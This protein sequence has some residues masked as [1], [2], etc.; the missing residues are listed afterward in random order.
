MR[1]TLSIAL[2]AVIGSAV[3]LHADV[4]KVVTDFG[5]I[6]SLVQQVMGDLGKPVM[7]LPAGGDPHDFQMRPSQAA[8]LSAADLVFWDGPELMPSLAD[9]ITTLGEDSKVVALLHRGGGTTRN[10][11]GD[12]GIDPHAWLDP[13][14]AQAW[15]GTIAV[16]LAMI[17]PENAATYAA[18]AS[19][20]QADVQAL[21]AELAT[22]L[23]PVRDKP[24]V[25]F[26]DA[27][28]HFA[29][30]FGLRVVGAIELGDATAPSA[31]RLVEI[32]GLLADAKA[33]CVFPEAGRDPKFIATVVEGS[34]V[35]IGGGQDVEGITLQ[36]GPAL[37]GDLL[38]GLATT[39][40]DCLTEN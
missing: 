28:G 1:Y 4:P 2:A 11:T 15:L 16:E 37:Y 10:Y 21:D 38:R 29:D 23:A 40:V 26:H 14:N 5:P 34:A 7:L 33:V 24:F 18:N 27:L 3:A 6:D 25:V 8:A 17:D 30:H 36:P 13:V 39:L 22:L 35:R 31:A 20:A 9:A 32:A 19:A 12:A